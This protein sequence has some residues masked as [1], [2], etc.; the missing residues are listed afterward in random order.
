MIQKPSISLIFQLIP[1][2]FSRI[3]E[4]NWPKSSFLWS[5]NENSRYYR[6]KIFGIEKISQQEKAVIKQ[7][8]S[9]NSE[10]KT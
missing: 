7:A 1:K 5:K 2:E 8:T 4:R 10:E 3:K 9:H 6:Q